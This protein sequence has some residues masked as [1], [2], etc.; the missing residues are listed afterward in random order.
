MEWDEERLKILK[1]LR[2]KG[3]NPYPQKFEFTHT[4]AQVIEEAN[5]SNKKT[6]EPFLFNISTVG[7]VGNVRRHGK[8]SFID[9]FD[10]G[11]KLQLYA[12]VNE[13]G[14]E[15]Y[16]EFIHI[17]GRGDIIGV[18]GDL[19]YTMKG[20]LTLRIK[21]YTLLS[22]ALIEPPDWSKLTPEFRY[23][24]R[25]V[26]FLYNSDARELMLKRFN[27]I[28]QIRSYL[29][30][31][32][33]MEVETPVLQPVYGGALAKPFKSHVNA[34]NED[35]YLRISLELYLKRYIVGGFNKVFEIGKVFRNEDID[36]THNPEYTLMELYWAYADYKDIMNLT[37]NLIREVARSV[38]KEPKIKKV[39]NG[40]EYEIDL[41]KPFNKV[42]MYD[43]LSNAI[44]KNIE[45]VS[46]D[47]LKRMLDE[48]G[49]KPRGNLYIRGFMIEKLFDKLVADNIIEPTF[50]LDYPI[51]TT[52][53][54][55]PHRSKPGLVERFELYAVGMELAN[56]YT[57]LNDPVLQDEL[58]KKE[59]EMMKRGDEE[60]HPY[61][62]DFVRALSYGMPPTGG[63][64]IGIDRL[65]ML[66]TGVYS[67]KEIIPYP[68]ISYKLIEE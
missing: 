59:M 39:I 4:I 11:E 68:M 13:L 21:D 41:D 60:A 63:V 28:Q 24:H 37:E 15:R 33:F 1:E 23:A 64:G 26:D 42:T 7:R 57:E 38:L 12:R 47:E 65:V 27:I 54:C 52:P 32:G 20:E 58:F 8:A 3:I 49:Q 46:D 50:I 18:K 51:E 35:W 30:K 56:A 61:D 16:N 25:Y 67:I 14:E 10:E 36:V 48:I 62:F 22:K 6:H 19:F 29:Y 45:T 34:L 53:L 2:S 55:K 17:I 43:A 40:K 31:Q 66:L 9:I 5:K 44:G